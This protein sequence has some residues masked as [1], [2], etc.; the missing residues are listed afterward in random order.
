[1]KENRMGKAI[2]ITLDNGKVFKSEYLQ[3]AVDEL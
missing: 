1:M 3:L 2:S